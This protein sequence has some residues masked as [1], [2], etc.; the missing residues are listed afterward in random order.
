LNSYHKKLKSFIA[1][2]LTIAILTTQLPITTFAASTTNSR[3]E[4]HPIERL[5]PKNVL[6]RAT[7][8]PVELKTR[9]TINSRQ[10]INPD[11]TFTI[12]TSIKPLHYQD[13]KGNLQLI[14]NELIPSDKPGYSNQNKANSF[15]VVSQRIIKII[16]WYCLI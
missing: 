1:L 15:R 12:E 9:R 16:I 6:P 8:K 13:E 14:D 7:D 3:A 10:Y 11:G 4:L 2:F 5:T